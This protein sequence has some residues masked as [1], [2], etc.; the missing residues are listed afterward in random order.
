MDVFPPRF[1]LAAK[2]AGAGIVT[3]RMPMSSKCRR[4]AQSP[5]IGGKRIVA[6][7]GRSMMFIALW[8]TEARRNYFRS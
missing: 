6:R 8:L 4:T 7:R 2:E 3:G 1:V 5:A